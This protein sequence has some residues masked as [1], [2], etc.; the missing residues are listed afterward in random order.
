MKKIYVIA[1]TFFFISVNQAQILFEKGYFIDYRNARIDCLIRNVDWKNNPEKFD[2]KLSENAE[3]K[4]VNI[5]ET[6]EFG[7]GNDLKLVRFRVGIDRSSSDINKLSYNRLPEF[8]QEDL[9]LKVI[10]EGKATLYQYSSNNT[11]RFFYTIDS[12]QPQ[13]LVYKSYKI[14]DSQIGKNEGYKQQLLEKFSCGNASI[15]DIDKIRYAKKDLTKFF[16]AY[17]QCTSGS[18][19]VY[20]EKTQRDFFNLSIRPRYTKSSLS[21]NQN[22]SDFRDANFG[23]KSQ[24][25][26]GLEAEFILPFNKNKWTITLEPTYDSFKAKAPTDNQSVAIDYKAITLPIGVR[27]YM[28]LNNNSKFF[29][30]VVYILNFDLNSTFDY[31]HT[32]DFDVTSRNNLGFGAGFKFK[33]RFIIEVRQALETDLIGNSEGWNADYKQ[34]SL[35]LGYTLF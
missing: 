6:K 16:A 31:E 35:I 17:N 30:N 13:Q 28:Y 14:N 34:S 21:I 3:I 33:D 26:I 22:I 9:F 25:G 5:K 10:L 4:T 8:K 1:L 20:G 23:S 24:F 27:H 11:E 15:N 7:I 18:S 12:L 29:I 32:L 19:I 2:Y